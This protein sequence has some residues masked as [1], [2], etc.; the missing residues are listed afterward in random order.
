MGIFLWI[1]VGLI[2]GFIAHRVFDS[3]GGMIG[4]LVLGLIGALVGGYL[5][6]ILNLNV[7]GGFID[8]LIIATCGAVL[9]LFLKRKVF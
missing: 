2:A 9:L 1:I 5:A 3:R 6:N 4:S 8:Q 7:T